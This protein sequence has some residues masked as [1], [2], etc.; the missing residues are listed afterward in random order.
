[1][2]QHEVVSL[3][4]IVGIPCDELTQYPNPDLTL[5]TAHNHN[6][7]CITSPLGNPDHTLDTAQDARLRT[8]GWNRSQSGL[9][10]CSR[11]YGYAI[12]A[13]SQS[14][15]GLELGLQFELRLRFGFGLG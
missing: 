13:G 11:G 10:L 15:L 8:G 7:Y 3:G 1:M 14:G 9:G 5:D 12:R 6:P 4:G 2:C